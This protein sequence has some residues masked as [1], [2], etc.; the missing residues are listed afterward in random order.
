MAANESVLVVDDE[1]DV[2]T[3]VEDI[4]VGEGYPVLGAGDPLEA[5]GVARAQPISLLVTDVVMPNMNGCEL[6]Q[7]IEAMRPHTKVLFM[8]AA[9]PDGVLDPRS[10]FIAKPFTVDGLVHAVGRVLRETRLR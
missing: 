2:R 4:L 5:L 10:Q 3:L 1:P 6:A 9:A 7:R 8:S